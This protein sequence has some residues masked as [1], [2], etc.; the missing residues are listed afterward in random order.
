MKDTFA[1]LGA[2]LLASGALADDFMVPVTKNFQEDSV[3]WQGDIAG[4]SYQY[5]YGLAAIDGKIAA[6]GVG[7]YLDPTLTG[8]TRQF[9]RKSHVEF[10][11]EVVLTDL[12]FFTK[13]PLKADLRA[14]KATC[15][16][17]TVPAKGRPGDFLFVFAGGHARL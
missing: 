6:C 9:L 11:G 13:V 17:T 1:L 4:K 12:S 10:N 5:V 3:V 15:R 7:K 14:A 16:L 2:I 8:P